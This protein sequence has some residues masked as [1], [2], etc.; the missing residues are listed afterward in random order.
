MKILVPIKRVIDPNIKPRVKSD[1]SGIDLQNVK[2]A[3]NPF[4]EIALE[5]AIRL[6]EAGIADEIL[7]VSIGLPQ[8]Q[9]ILRTALALGADRALWINGPADVEPLAVAKL[10]KALVEK[11]KSEMIILG[12]QAIDDDANQT[13]QML[14][15]LLDWPQACFASKVEFIEGKV[16]VESEI[17]G[18][19]QTVALELPCV[20]TTDLR[21]NTPRFAKLPDIMKARQKQ[22]ETLT[23]E[24]LK[25][26]ISPHLTL[27]K[28][29]APPPRKLG[30]T[31]STVDELL[32]KLRNVEK[33]IP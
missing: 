8:S 24:D 7:A 15:A 31:V 13:G 28:M 16:Q 21:L 25:V 10:L 2:M 26:D 17:D 27:L 1:G 32:D 11:E 9:E 22:I 3:A 18:G 19:H 33:L 12:K 30:T 6:K 5:E 14:A 23:A 29:Q 20:I 4:D